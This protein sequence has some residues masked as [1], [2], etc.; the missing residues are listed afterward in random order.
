M[1]LIWNLTKESCL[2][3]YLDLGSLERICY[4]KDLISDLKSN[5]DVMA[6]WFPSKL[7]TDDSLSLYDVPITIYAANNRKHLGTKLCPNISGLFKGDFAKIKNHGM[8]CKII[9]SKG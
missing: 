3:R 8:N 1:N 6:Q 9:I 2:S 7:C 4:N 5:I